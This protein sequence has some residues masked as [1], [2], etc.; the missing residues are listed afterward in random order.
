M[1]F[2]AIFAAVGALYNELATGGAKAAA[3]KVLADIAEVLAAVEG[4]SSNSSN[5]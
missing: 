2:V 5:G 4:A 1:N 3:D